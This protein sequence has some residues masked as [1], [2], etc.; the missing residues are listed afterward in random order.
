M[1]GFGDENAAGARACRL[2]RTRKAGYDALLLRGAHHEGSWRG[3]WGRRVTGVADSFPG[4]DTVAVTVAT[5]GASCAFHGGL[6]WKNY[7]TKIKLM[8]CFAAN[9]PLRKT[10][11]R[12]KARNR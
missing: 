12:W 11:R 8:P 1:S 3:A 2:A 9:A 10:S 4:S 5:D 7:S 6:K